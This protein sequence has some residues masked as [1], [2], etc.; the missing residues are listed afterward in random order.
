MC[1]LTVQVKNVLKNVHVTQ[2]SD[3]IHESVNESVLEK[4]FDI[5][6]CNA[7]DP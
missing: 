1:F 5:G 7:L 4:A 6:P 2:Q 3:I